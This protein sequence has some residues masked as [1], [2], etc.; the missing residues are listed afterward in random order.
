MSWENKNKYD[1]ISC[2][3]LFCNIKSYARK[4]SSGLYRNHY[5]LLVCRCRFVSCPSLFFSLT[6]L[7]IFGT[8]VRC[9][10]YIHDFSTTGIFD[11]NVKFISFSCQTRNSCLLCHQP[12]IFVIW[13]YYHVTTCRVHSWSRDDVDFWP[14]GVRATAILPCDIAM[15]Y[16]AHEYIDV[17]PLDDLLHELKCSYFIFT[18]L[19]LVLKESE[20]TENRPRDL[21]HE[22]IHIIRAFVNTRV[23][24]IRNDLMPH[25]T[26]YSHM[27]NVNVIRIWDS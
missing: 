2:T 6:L 12:I 24:I 23:R 1:W 19:F 8:W 10:A 4:R 13:V 25:K 20:W 3:K 9:S 15:P 27:I 7:I 17:S 18:K 5:R 22:F 26:Y 16:L 21:F 14:Q 11:L